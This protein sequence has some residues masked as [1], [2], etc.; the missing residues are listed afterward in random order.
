MCDHYY[1]DC[2][3]CGGRIHSGSYCKTCAR[4]ADPWGVIP[5]MVNEFRELTARYSK[6]REAVATLN[7]N[8]SDAELHP[9]K[10]VGLF[11]TENLLERNKPM[12]LRICSA[13]VR[14]P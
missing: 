8:L 13:D 4:K 1:K 9:F 11:G 5:T 12:R 6:V 7:S 2:K 14:K 3:I 10:V